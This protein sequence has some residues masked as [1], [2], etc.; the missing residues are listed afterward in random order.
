[1]VYTVEEL[2]KKQKTKNKKQKTKNKKQKTKNKKQK[3]IK[4]QNI[5]YT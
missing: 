5:K 1:M 3:T 4:L 2:N